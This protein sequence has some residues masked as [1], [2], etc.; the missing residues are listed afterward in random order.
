MSR[1]EI[2]PGEGP[3]LG[4]IGGSRPD[5]FAAAPESEGFPY[6]LSVLRSKIW[7]VLL[8]VAI[9]VVA[10][11][12]ALS[13]ASEVYQAQ[14]DLL[15]TPVPGDNTALVGLGLPASSS[16]PTRD[17]ETIARLIKTQVVARRVIKVLKLDTTPAALL[18]KIDATPVSSSDVVA[19]TARAGDSRAAAALANAFANASVADRTARLNRQLDVVI[20][21]LRKQLLQLRPSE[22]AARET[23]SQRLRDFEALRASGDPTIRLAVAA[24]PNPSAISPRPA[25]TLAAAILAGLFIAIAAVF[26]SQF[27]DPR[28]RREEQLRRYRIPVLARVPEERGVPRRSKESPLLPGALSAAAH[29]SY[30]LLA[31]TLSGGAPKRSVMVTGPTSGDGKTTSALSL[32]TAIATTERVILVEGDSRRPS[33]GRSLGLG[34]KHG[35]SSVLAGR[36]PLRDALVAG[37]NKAPG[38]QFLFQVGTEPPLG[39]IATAAR[40]RT[41]IGEAHALANWLIIDAPPLAVVPDAIPIAQEVDDVVL[42]VR[43][44]NTRLKDLARLAELLVQQNITPSGFVLIGGKST[45]PYYA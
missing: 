16:D 26:G 44:G 7:F 14:A 45:N 15:I 32:A 13:R 42:V 30:S 22:T 27:V 4:P 12:V 34:G 9:C 19:V 23:L 6:Y 33:L 2:G 40:A 10:A 8:I 1:A 25:L 39:S 3:L 18:K 20:P 37:D 5:W 41:M 11:I 17:I 35:P 21:Q 28:L 24:E 29:D 38:V 31:A 36:T 43:L